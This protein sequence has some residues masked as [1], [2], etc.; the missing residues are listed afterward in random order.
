MSLC[1]LVHG[2]VCVCVRVLEC[3]LIH[4]RVYLFGFLQKEDK[5]IPS[6]IVC[7]CARLYAYIVHSKCI[8]LL[9]DVLVT[10]LYGLVK[11]RYLCVV[12]III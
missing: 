7:V 8:I 3:I 5:T 4:I 2:R 9:L 11:Q 12:D 1:A 10:H 6:N